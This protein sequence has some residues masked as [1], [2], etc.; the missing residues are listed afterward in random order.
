MASLFKVAGFGDPAKLSVYRDKRFRGNQEEYE[1]ALQA[2]TTV[3]IGNMSFYTTEEQVYELFSRAGE[4]K[5]I[6]MGLDKNTKTPCGF[7]FVLNVLLTREFLDQ[8][9]TLA[10]QLIN[11]KVGEAKRGKRNCNCKRMRLQWQTKAADDVVD[12]EDRQ[13]CSV[14]RSV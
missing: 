11:R 5:K 10:N 4:I 7:C 2:S 13:S 1:R 8:S 12:D 9:W 6:I 14:K 3:Y